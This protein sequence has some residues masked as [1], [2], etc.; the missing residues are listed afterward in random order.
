MPRFES[1]GRA[2]ENAPRD[3]RAPAKAERIRGRDPAMAHAPRRPGRAEGAAALRRHGQGAARHPGLGCR[4]RASSRKT[5]PRGHGGCPQDGAE[6]SAPSWGQPQRLRCLLLGRERVR[7]TL[8]PAAAQAWAHPV[9]GCPILAV[10]AA[11]LRMARPPARVAHGRTRSGAGDA[12][13]R[14]SAIERW[15]AAG[16]VWP[17]R[18]GGL[19]AK[20]RGASR[21]G[22]LVHLYFYDTQSWLQAVARPEI[23]VAKRD[24]GFVFIRDTGV[25]KRRE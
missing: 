25:A 10:M 5:E 11:H 23:R 21:D 4:C 14:E 2:F 9:P 3:S 19:L 15:R 16:C 24:I 6:A 17:A 18:V 22:A 20:R 12:G 1:T 8:A 13:T 7:A